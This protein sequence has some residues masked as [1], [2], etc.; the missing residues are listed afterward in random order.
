MKVCEKRCDQCLFSNNRIVP[1][2]RKE[3]I[4]RQCRRDDTHFTCHKATLRGEDVQ[5]R[6]YFDSQPPSQMTRIA[7]RLGVLKFVPNE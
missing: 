6:G 5:C 7:E 1:A 4:I 3:Q 2:K